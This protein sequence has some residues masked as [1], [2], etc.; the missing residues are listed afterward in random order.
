MELGFVLK[1]LS[2]TLSLEPQTSPEKWRMRQGKCHIE[3]YLTCPG[4]AASL[5]ARLVP[6][7]SGSLQPLVFTLHTSRLPVPGTSPFLNSSSG[8]AGQPWHSNW[9]ALAALVTCGS[10]SGALVGMHVY[11]FICTW[12]RLFQLP[13]VQRRRGKRVCPPGQRLEFHRLPNPWVLIP[14][15]WEW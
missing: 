4:A 9:W 13:K 12:S 7:S 15:L 14:V 3:K 1:T 6:Q 11:Q 5:S 8:Q 2:F 10:T